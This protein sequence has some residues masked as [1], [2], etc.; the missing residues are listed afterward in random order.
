MAKDNSSVFVVLGRNPNY[1]KIRIEKIKDSLLVKH[2]NITPVYLFAEDL[3]LLNLRQEIDNL[4]FNKRMFIFK[5]AES[6]SG[7]IKSYLSKELK[8]PDIGDVFIFD[9]DAGIEDIARFKKDSFFSFLFRINPPFKMGGRYR[10]VSLR[11]LAFALRR[12]SPEESLEI[13]SLLFDKNPKEKI[14][15]QILGLII[16]VVTDNYSD[17]RLRKRWINYLF[18]ADRQLKEGLLHPQRALEFLVLRIKS[19]NEIGSSN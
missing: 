1:K 9:F 11:D 14:S 10:D 12:N 13:I 2:S 3:I 16:K 19:G 15:M 8:K 5:S 4:S 6:L 7:E 17:P 18:Q